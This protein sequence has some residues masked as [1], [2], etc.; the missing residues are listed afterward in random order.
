MNPLLLAALRWAARAAGA[1][2]IRKWFSKGRE[3]RTMNGT[4]AWWQSR[5]VLGPMVATLAFGLKMAFGVDIGESEQAA[6][7][8]GLLNLTV[9]GG[10]LVGVWGRITAS[11]RIG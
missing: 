10:A 11:K 7:I 2:L 1:G 6:L 5:G 3:H 4:K 8:D 9:F